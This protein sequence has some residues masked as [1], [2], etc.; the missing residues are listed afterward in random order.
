MREKLIELLD[1]IHHT[2][3]GKTYRER[4]ETIADFLITNGVRLETKQATSEK[5][6]E[7]NMRWIAVSER[8][9]EPFKTVL[10]YD[11]NN[12]EICTAYQTRNMEWV[13]I[14]LNGEVIYWA[15]IPE[16]TKEVE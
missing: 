8:P 6:S 5:A 1:T 9:P 2:P 15:P 14:R 4:I 3:L 11:R 7:E 12:K 10:V 13:G 16:S